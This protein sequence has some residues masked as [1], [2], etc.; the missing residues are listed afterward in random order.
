[1]E[2]GRTGERIHWGR[3]HRFFG[4]ARWDADA[5]GL[6]LARVIVTCF[7]PPGAGITVAVDDSLYPRYGRKIFRVAWQHDGC[8]RGRDGLGRGNCFVVAG[9][10]VRLPF[11]ARMVCLPVL[12][13]LQIPKVSPSKTEQARALVDLLACAFAD[14]RI[15][16]VGDAAYRGPAWRTLPDRLT[17]TTRLAANAVLYGPEPPRTGTRGHPRWKGDRLGTP[18]ESAAA[19]AWR[20]TTM[21]FYGESQTVQLCQLVCL[22]WG[23]LRRRP[24]QVVLMRKM[25]SPR[26]YDG[27]LVTTDLAGTPEQVVAR[28]AARWS[29]EQSIK[30]GKDLLGVGEAHT[31]TQTTVERTVPFGM[32]CLSLLILWYAHAGRAHVD[33]AACRAAAPWYRHKRHVSIADMIIAFRR[34]RITEATAV[35]PA[36]ALFDPTPATCDATAA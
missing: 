6:A 33:L 10:V 21:V 13:R 8:A 7:L 19:A 30:D 23:S 35:Q 32:C 9:I 18:A 15:H 29:I 4:Q 27:A 5:L 11:L 3:A 25:D 36:L 20:T 24:V 2:C 34:A 17:F 31:R 1:V 12:F 28:Y 14:R 16:F 26:T 22:W